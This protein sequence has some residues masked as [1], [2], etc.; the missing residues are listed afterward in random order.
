[1]EQNYSDFMKLERNSLILEGCDVELERFHYS[2]NNYGL[3]E[4]WIFGIDKAGLSQNTGIMKDLEL[5][6]M[7]CI[8]QKT[9]I[10]I[11]FQTQLAELVIG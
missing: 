7:F 10:S 11:Y 5:E 6:L 9:F 4:I 3:T 2:P 8:I 1:M